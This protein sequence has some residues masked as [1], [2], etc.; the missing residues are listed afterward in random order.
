MKRLIAIIM[1]MALLVP[2]A[3]LAGEP[4]VGT[5][6]MLFDKSVT[7]EIADLFQGYDLIVA[8]Y[9]FMENGTVILTENDILNGNSE[10]HTGGSGKWEKKQTNYS[11]SIIGL[12]SGE[13]YVKDDM[14]YLEAQNGVYLK[15]RR[16]IP[17]NPYQDYQY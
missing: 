15:L 17:F 8:A 1:I 2:A 3:A 11:Y 7:P 10:P 6:Y 16:M 9:S 13:A 14:I 12:G 5:W 4:I